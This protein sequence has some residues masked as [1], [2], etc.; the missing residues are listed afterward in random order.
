MTCFQHL[1]LSG[2]SPLLNGMTE[3]RF[4]TLDQIV[5]ARRRYLDSQKKQVKRGHHTIQGSSFV[6][7]GTLSVLRADKEA[8][9][10]RNGGYIDKKVGR[11]T[12][13]LVVGDTGRH[14]RTTKIQDAANMGVHIINEEE[15]DKMIRDHNYRPIVE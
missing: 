4:A 14:G 1:Q 2:R 8:L 7:T 6:I 11:R 5:E 15:L 3:T 13:Y 9:I 12:T 10:S